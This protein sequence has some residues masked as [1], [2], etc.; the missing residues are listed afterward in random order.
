MIM[1]LLLL[2]LFRGM[3]VTQISNW[4][5]ILEG[6]GEKLFQNNPALPEYKAKI[7]GMKHRLYKFKIRTE[8]ILSKMTKT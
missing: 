1:L 5:L 2:Y 4:E 7:E 6:L 8:S 3:K